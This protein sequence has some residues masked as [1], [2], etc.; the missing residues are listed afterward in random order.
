MSI[1]LWVIICILIAD[2]LTGLIHWAE[3]CYCTESIPFIGSPVCK[4]NIDHH[5]FPTLMNEVKGF[6]RHTYQS[7][8]IALM[9]FGVAYLFGFFSWQLLLIGLIAGTG[10]QIHSWNHEAKSSYFIQWLKDSGLIQSQRQHNIHHIPPYDRCYCVLINFNNAWLDRIYFWRGLE[11]ILYK[12]G[13]N[14]KRGTSARDG[15]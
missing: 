1:T 5:K 12:C 4:P 10:N 8:I 6:I 7:Y 2:F 13:L 9:V 14:V 15:Y 11:W 3:D